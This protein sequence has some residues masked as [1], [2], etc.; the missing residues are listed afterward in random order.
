M[1]CMRVSVLGL[2][3]LTCVGCA[4]GPNT[5]APEEVLRFLDA[6]EDYE[7]LGLTEHIAVTEDGRHTRPGSD[8][9]EWWYLDGVADDGT[10]V[11]VWFGDNWL[12]GTHT[13][14]VSIE[15]TAPGKPT[16][17]ALFSTKAAGEYAKEKAD[18]HI[19]GHSFVGDLLNYEIK[20]DA[21]DTGGLGCDLTLKRRVPSYR[22]GT[23]Y[24][25]TSQHYFAWLVAVPEG[26]LSGTLMVDGQPIRFHGSGY[27]DHNWGDVP[28]WDLMRNW[29]WGRGHVDGRTVVMADL[30]PAAGRGDASLPLLFVASPEGV[31]LN[32]YGSKVNLA[33][34][35]LRAHGDLKHEAPIAD[36]VTL[37]TPQTTDAAPTV[38][39]VREASPITSYDLLM[40]T[41]APWRW[42]ARLAG[43]SPW[44]T[45][46]SSRVSIE[47]QGQALQGTGT[48]EFMDFE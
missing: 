16:R 11:V 32:V 3:V 7:R 1:A 21:A 19:A 9:Y 4:H 28:P 8:E 46:W 13:R 42:L 31:S 12:V 2:L 36:S 24:M 47:N 27:H 14:Q 23:G 43:R 6:P 44:Y 15:V 10:V 30:R 37:T 5:I 26:E 39:F 17:R 22:P 20:V 41:A 35:P 45:R 18:V 33:E 40:A 25:G 38:R 29:W 48:L 34:G